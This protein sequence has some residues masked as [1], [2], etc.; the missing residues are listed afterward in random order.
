MGGCVEIGRTA[1]DITIFQFFKTAAATIQDF[2]NFKF[3]T[4]GGFKKVEV[5]C[6]AKFGRNRLNRYR[7]MA[8]PRFFK[9]SAAAGLDF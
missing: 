5:R 6:R 3:L 8:I 7:D 2:Q 9:I 4:V 1:V